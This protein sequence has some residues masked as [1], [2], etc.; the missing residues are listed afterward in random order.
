MRNGS[1][2]IRRP[3]GQ[4]SETSVAARYITE[5]RFI[6]RVFHIF[7]RKTQFRVEFRKGRDAKTTRRQKKRK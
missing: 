7:E 2:H 3:A 6:P 5:F 1:Y 4:R